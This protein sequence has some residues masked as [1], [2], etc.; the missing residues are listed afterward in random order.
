M[1]RKIY[2]NLS[3]DVSPLAVVGFVLVTFLMIQSARMRGMGDFADMHV[4]LPDV[5]GYETC[6]LIAKPIYVI[7]LDK[8]QRL[9]LLLEDENHHEHLTG[10]SSFHMFQ[11]T[12]DSLLA[13]SDNLNRPKFIIRADKNTKMPVIQRLLNCFLANGIQKFA[14]Q[15]DANSPKQKE[16]WKF[17]DVQQSVKNSILKKAKTL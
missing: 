13:H 15:V 14:L 4:R 1:R 16:Y 12:I 10:M 2:H 11:H 5:V 8:T 7:Y 6:V 3:P 17:L 9:Y